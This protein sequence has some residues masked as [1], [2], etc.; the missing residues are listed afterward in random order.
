[1]SAR[2][3][4]KP[5]WARWSIARENGKP[6]RSGI[7]IAVGRVVIRSGNENVDAWLRDSVRVGRRILREHG[8]VLRAGVGQLRSTPT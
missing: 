2:S 6:V 3:T 8:A 4:F 7:D 1:M 5:I